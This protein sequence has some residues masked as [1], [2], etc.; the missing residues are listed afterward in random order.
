MDKPAQGKEAAGITF[1][2]AKLQRAGLLLYRWDGQGAFNY[3]ARLQMLDASKT[4]KICDADSKTIAQMSGA[5][6]L[7]Q[8][9]DVA[10]AEGRLSALIFIEPVKEAGK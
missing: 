7:A 5:D 6:L 9:F 10:F 4:Y 8:G 3:H 1:Y 2:D